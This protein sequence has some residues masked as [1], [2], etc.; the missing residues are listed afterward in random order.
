V[1]YPFHLK[2]ILYF[3]KITQ[4]F[5]FQTNSIKLFC[6]R[7]FVSDNC[8]DLIPDYLMILRGA[9]DSPDI[10]LNVSRSALQMDRTVRSLSTHISKKVA[11]RLSSIYK[12]D[13]E[14]F[15]TSWQDIEMIIKLGAMQ[16]EKFYVDLNPKKGT[17]LLHRFSCGAEQYFDLMADTDYV[18]TLDSMEWRKKEN[19]NYEGHIGY[20]LP[21]E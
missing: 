5:D 20:V 6:N 10:P 7:V 2:G 1:D 12:T 13:R 3:P 21:P 15:L 17:K 9:I 8:K 18:Y 16:D 14:Q 19:C 4:R 11:D